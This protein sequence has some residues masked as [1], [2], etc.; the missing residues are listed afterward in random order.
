MDEASGVDVRQEG[1]DERSVVLGMI[2]SEDWHSRLEA[3]RVAREKALAARKPAPRPPLRLVPDTPVES[4][5]TTPD[6][7]DDNLEFDFPKLAEDPAPDTASG[8]EQFLRAQKTGA[9]VFRRTSI[10]ERPQL[11]L[12]EASETP[13][14][15]A[16]APIPSHSRELMTLEAVPVVPAERAA[17]SR[18]GLRIIAGFAIGLVA[19]VAATSIIWLSRPDLPPVAET[20]VATAAPTTATASAAPAAAPA[21]ADPAALAAPAEAA[22]AVTAAV[23]PVTPSVTEPPAAPQA[24]DA[25]PGAARLPDPVT[26]SPDVLT[27]AQGVASPVRTLAPQPAVVLSSEAG[28]PVSVDLSPFRPAALTQVA[29]APAPQA[30]SVPGSVA[31]APWPAPSGLAP[32]DGPSPADPAPQPAALPPAPVLA[33]LSSLIPPPDP[34]RAVAPQPSILTVQVLAPARLSDEEVMAAA[35]SV[36][37][38]GYALQDPAR[39]AVTVRETHVRY[40][41]P[42]DRAAAEQLAIWFGGDARDFTGSASPV[43]PGTVELWLEGTSPSAAKPKPARAGATKQARPAPAETPEMQALRQRILRNLQGG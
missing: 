15:T 9:P 41:N 38:A 32:L 30:D 29:F 42:A 21:L 31:L 25:L 12:P 13:Q 35:E 34:R 11:V 39:V 43:P 36:R 33:P 8:I 14:D 5:P 10:A 26:A 18:I 40:Y 2:S 19:G 27:I 17:A 23:L 4:R 7:M 1:A 3:A 37:S 28:L 6:L 24:T 22:P 20:T 16:L